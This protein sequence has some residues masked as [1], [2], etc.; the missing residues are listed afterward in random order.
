MEKQNLYL[1]LT[2]ENKK[3]LS[4][5]YIGSEAPVPDGVQYLFKFSNGYGAS[6]VKHKYSK[7]WDWDEWELSIQKLHKTDDGGKCWVYDYSHPEICDGNAGYLSD[8]QVND[9]LDKIRGL[10]AV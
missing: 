1:L 9:L 3:F 2:S 8:D 6:V 5:M 10:E 7:G 4:V